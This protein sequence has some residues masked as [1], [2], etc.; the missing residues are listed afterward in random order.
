MSRI[1]TLGAAA[2]MIVALSAAANAAELLMYRTAGCSWCAQW[3]AVIGPIYPKTEVG[4]RAPIR[5]VDRDKVRGPD[6]A[7]TR[8]V[9]YS[10]TFVLV[11]E[12]REIGRIEGYPGEDFFWGLLENLVLNLP[13]RD[14]TIGAAPVR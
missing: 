9:R 3:D 12:G 5:M 10:P 8:P 13:R 1:R 7:L 4:R 2:V 14:S 11:D 6:I